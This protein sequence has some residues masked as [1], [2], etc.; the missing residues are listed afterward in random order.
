MALS[1]RARILIGALVIIVCFSSPTWL[2][3]VISPHHRIDWLPLHPQP[4]PRF[5]R[6]RDVHLQAYWLEKGRDCAC[7]YL[8]AAVAKRRRTPGVCEAECDV[9]GVGEEQ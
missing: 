9:G 6:P 8:Y 2:C 4:H 3:P 1:T 5:L 7:V